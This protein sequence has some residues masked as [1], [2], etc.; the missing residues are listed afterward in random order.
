MID[1]LIKYATIV[2]MATLTKGE[3]STDNEIDLWSS[4][5][6]T[7]PG[8]LLARARAVTVQH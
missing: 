7:D 5:L 2:P 8:F 6:A 3:A 1:R 4:Q